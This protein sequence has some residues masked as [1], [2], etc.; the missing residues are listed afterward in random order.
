[1]LYFISSSKNKFIEAKA[2]IPELEQLAVDLPEIQSLDPHEVIKAKLETASIHIRPHIEVQPQCVVVEDTS[3]YLD[4]LNGKLPGVFTKW[5]EKAL[6][7]EGIAKLA[8]KNPNA[9]AVCMIGY[10]H[11]NG[12]VKFFEGEMPGTIVPPRGK[13]DFGFDAIFQP[14]GYDQTF[15]EMD[16]ATKNLISHRKQAFEKLK[17]YLYS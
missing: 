3:L 5:F 16:L 11:S 13:R 6:G 17:K 9:R 4:A 8:L 2:I 1:M 14:T 7:V 10:A 12:E 15:G